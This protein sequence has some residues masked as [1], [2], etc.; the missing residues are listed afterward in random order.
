[1]FRVNSILRTSQKQLIRMFLFRFEFLQFRYPEQVSEKHL[2][3]KLQNKRRQSVDE[4]YTLWYT[5]HTCTRVIN[6]KISN[7]FTNLIIFSVNM[8]ECIVIYH[9]Y[10]KHYH[11]NSNEWWFSYPFNNYNYMYY[12]IYYH[13][14]YDWSLADVNWNL[15]GTWKMAIDFSLSFCDRFLRTTSIKWCMKT[16]KM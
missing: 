3:F 15:N 14:I 2:W 11:Y 4:Q 10:T 7:A 13:M 1:M 8:K 6:V 9:T 12:I 5:N 16:L